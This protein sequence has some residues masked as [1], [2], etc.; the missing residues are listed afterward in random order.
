MA[1]AQTVGFAVFVMLPSPIKKSLQT[2]LGWE[3]R[4]LDFDQEIQD[5]VGVRVS[6]WQRSIFE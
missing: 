2:M 1:Y 6:A 4:I 5:C 3:Q